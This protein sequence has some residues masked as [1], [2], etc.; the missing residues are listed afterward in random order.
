M[1]LQ[2]TRTLSYLDQI[3]NIDA[4]DI[5]SRPVTSEKEK[6]SNLVAGRTRPEPENYF[7]AQIITI[8][9]LYEVFIQQCWQV[10]LIMFLCTQDK[11]HISGPN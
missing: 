9:N 1:R 10:I 4:E 7:E 2:F 3:A 6:I 11:K 5:F 8:K